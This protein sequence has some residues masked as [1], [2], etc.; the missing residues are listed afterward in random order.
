MTI[1]RRP[2]PFGE[3]LSLRQAMDRL[4]DDGFVRPVAW[5]A[6]ALDHA[7]LPVD[8][9]VT[10]NELVVEAQLPG[11]KPDDVEI[12]LENGMLKI[13]G[14]TTEDREDEKGDFV[15]REIRRGA[16]RRSISLPDGLQPD[17]AT[18]T[19]E[20]GVLSLRIPKADDVKPRQIR[21]SPTTNGSTNGH[22]SVPASD[23]Q[24]AG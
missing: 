21:I 14:E 3:L 11:L 24:K 6:T 22:R 19:F 4:F 8:V 20:N 1:A 18:A 13:S 7:R 10:P 5:N 16:I 12:T 17:K 23:E 15:V 2:S 9:S